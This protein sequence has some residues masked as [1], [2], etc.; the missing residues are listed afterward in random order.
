M[1]CTEPVERLVNGVPSGF[2]TCKEGYEVRV[3]A[4]SCPNLLPDKGEGGAA[5]AGLDACRTDIDCPGEL[6]YCVNGQDGAGY[7]VSGCRTDGDCQ[8]GQI[9]RCGDPVGVCSRAECQTNADCGPDSLCASLINSSCLVNYEY[10]CLSSLDECRHSA[11]CAGESGKSTCVIGDGRRQC[12]AVAVC[13]RPFL[14]DAAHRQAEV[15]G[16]S[17]WANAT[18]APDCSALTPGERSLLAE[19]WRQIGAMEHASIAAFARFQLQLLALGAPAE[20]VEQTNRAL[21]DET[22]HARLAFGLAGAYAGRA[23]GPGPLRTHDAL[24]DDSLGTLLETTLLEGCL[25]ET[26]A[27]LE[28]SLARDRCRDGAVRAVLAGIAGD[29][30]RHAEL[31]W[32]FLAYCLETFP[33]LAEVVEGCLQRMD[34]SPD[35]GSS[36]S[37]ATPASALG[38]YGVLSSAERASLR[39]QVIDEVVAPMD[40]SHFI[41]KFRWT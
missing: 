29:E 37:A 18:L 23:V 8:V 27:T 35:S 5:G 10:A 32:R 33:Q 11:D 41:A 21:V 28:A 4:A 36:E 39:V 34:V 13:G 12:A 25:G 38:E 17:D 20:L 1:G 7:C 6:E 14:V 2:A 22:R 3:R 9:C 26:L 19:H 15:V 30:A 40:W 16:R 24:D 31:A